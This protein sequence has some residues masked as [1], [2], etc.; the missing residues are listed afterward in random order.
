MMSIVIIACWSMPVMA[1]PEANQTY[2]GPTN[3]YGL[4]V[5]DMTGRDKG[6][7]TGWNATD[8][9]IARDSSGGDAAVD[10]VPGEGLGTTEE[11][12]QDPPKQP[13]GT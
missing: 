2:D 13:D 1:Q 7:C 12:Q 4:P 10:D 3:I 5:E 6:T 8:G 9:A 11:H